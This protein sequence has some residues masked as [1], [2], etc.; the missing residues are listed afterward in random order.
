MV[1]DF[2]GYLLMSS[3]NRWSIGVFRHTKRSIRFGSEMR[4]NIKRGLRLEVLSSKK[5]GD[6]EYEEKLRL[7]EEKVD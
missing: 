1:I 2:T 5:K 3:S 6:V 7:P 4:W